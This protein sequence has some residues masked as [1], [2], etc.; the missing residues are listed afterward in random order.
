MNKIRR[1]MQLDLGDR[2]KHIYCK[3][4]RCVD[5]LANFGC[6]YVILTKDFMFHVSPLKMIRCLVHDF[7]GVVLLP[8]LID[9]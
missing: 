1:L 9:L 5:I 8:H 2:L 6:E 3:A 7:S 4:N